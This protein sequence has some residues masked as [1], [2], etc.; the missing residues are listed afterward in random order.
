MVE[1]NKERQPKERIQIK[2][3]HLRATNRNGK[4]LRNKT[5]INDKIIQDITVA[6]YFFKHLKR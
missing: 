2:L 1:P 5:I 4:D 3:Y 6:F